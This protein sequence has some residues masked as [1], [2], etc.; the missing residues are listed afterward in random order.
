M[1]SSNGNLDYAQTG[2]GSNRCGP[3]ALPPYELQSQA[4]RFALK[5]AP[6]G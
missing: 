4:F 6:L 3:R 2:L 5:L 1:L